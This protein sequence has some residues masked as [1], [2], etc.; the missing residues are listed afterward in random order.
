MVLDQTSIGF[1]LYSSSSPTTR[2]TDS[3]Y[4]IMNKIGEVEIPCVWGQCSSISV[5]FG[6]TEIKATATNIATGQVVFDSGVFDSVVFSLFRPP[7][8][9]RKGV[10]GQ[11]QSKRQ[12]QR[13][14]HRQR[15]VTKRMPMVRTLCRCRQLT[16][17]STMVLIS[18]KSCQEECVCVCECVAA[19][20]GGAI[21]GA[22]GQKTHYIN[23]YAN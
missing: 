17:R 1:T 23:T 14:R 13:D 7:C 19:A 3:K 6:D 4:G 21:T 8:P 9:P 2:W 15:L 11:V 20:A 5:S 22:A 16:K 18:T 10:K 12:R